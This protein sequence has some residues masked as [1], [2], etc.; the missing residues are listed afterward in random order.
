MIDWLMNWFYYL[1]IVIIP[2][3]FLFSTVL[4]VVGILFYERTS[5]INRF[6]ITT[7]ISCKILKA[8][9]IYH[10]DYVLLSPLHYIFVT[11]WLSGSLKLLTSNNNFWHY[12]G[13]LFLMNWLDPIFICALQISY[14]S[15]MLICKAI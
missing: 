9:I 11:T 6:L 10:H 12:I 5:L 7:I 14:F 15:I 13:L 1:L 4:I 8:I 3:V 2:I